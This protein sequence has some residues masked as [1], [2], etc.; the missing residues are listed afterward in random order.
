M[1]CRKFGIF[2][3]TLKASAAADAPR[4]WAKTLVRI[5]PATRLRRIPA[6]TSAA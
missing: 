3:A 1:F 4:K 2:S 6:A 5:R